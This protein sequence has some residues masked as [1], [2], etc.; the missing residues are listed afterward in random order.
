M[1]TRAHAV[2]GVVACVVALGVVPGA[3]AGGCEK[4]TDCKGDRVCEG[5]VCLDPPPRVATHPESGPGAAPANDVH[6]TLESNESAATLWRVTG[7]MLV[8]GA[9]GRCAAAATS[10]FVC[11]APCKRLLD[12]NAKYVIQGVSG[13]ARSTGEFVLPARAS[14]T[15]RV[16]SHSQTGFVLGTVFAGLSGSG[17]VVGGSLWGVGAGVGADG[18]ARAG[19]VVTLVS[20]PA[21]LGSIYLIA[22]NMTDVT[23]DHGETLAKTKRRESVAFDPAVF[24]WVF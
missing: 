8:C 23:T 24:G 22:H 6:V 20:V 11:V 3:R 5:G 13:P 1:F 12:R 10:E 16:E 2:G 21:L 17:L 15:V 7:R 4:D 19:L 9:G 14:V 18:L